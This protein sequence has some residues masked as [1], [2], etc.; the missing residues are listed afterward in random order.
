MGPGRTTVIERASWRTAGRLASSFALLI[1]AMLLAAG[2]GSSAQSADAAEDAPP[3]KGGNLVV[4][5]DQQPQCLNVVI[6][7][8]G[9]AVTSNITGPLFDSL[10]TVDAEGQDAP[11]IATEVPSTDNGRVVLTPEGGMVVTLDMQPKARWSDGKPITCEDVVFA[12]KLRMDE[13]WLVRSREGYN[14]LSKIDCVTPLRP[15]FHFK[16]RYAP[17][18][19]IVGIA[20]MPKHVLDGKDFNTFLSDEVPIS[21]GPFVFSHW[22]RSVEIVLKRNEDYWNAGNDDEPWL[23]SITFKFI[24]DSNTLKIQ[25]RTGE[26]DVIAPPPDSS[27]KEELEAMPRGSFSSEPGAYWEQL[28]F[29]TGK[30]PLN[31]R[32]VRL[33]IAFSIDRQQLAD[34]V[35]RKQVGVLQSTLLEGQK[36][37]YLPAWKDIKPDPKKATALL[38]KA[39]YTKDGAYYAKGGK[40]LTVV[41]KSTAGNN[42][43]LKVAQLLQQKLKGSGIKMEIAMEP[44]EV[45]FGQSTIQGNFDIALWAWSSTTDPSQRTLFSCDKIPTDAN[46]YE[47]NNYYR[48]CNDEVTKL[49]TKADVT[50]DVGERAAAIKQVQQLMRADMPMIPLFQRPDTVAFSN[51]AKGMDVN[52]FGGMT[53]N[54]YDWSVV[55]K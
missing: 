44:A 37:Y 32:D 27:L 12:W 7:C 19:G 10:L 8:G 14:L 9:M 3:Q 5:L 54:T 39:G 11:L 46:E 30:A 1:A 52:P 51:R 31:N 26:V 55:A 25:L 38:E 15:V 34:V 49:L 29:N 36:D 48:Y 28:A 35:L 24:P 40:P 4:G 20:P 6:V 22:D 21:S 17:F 47:G 53:W 43:R 16:E 2:C 13:R 23:D 50:P 18:L 33:A 45:F 41:F 42:L